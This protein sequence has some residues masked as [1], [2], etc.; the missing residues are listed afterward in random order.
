MIKQNENR[1]TVGSKTSTVRPPSTVQIMPESLAGIIWRSRLIVFVTTLAA[2]I[3]VLVY[4][5]KTAP[6]YM[7]TSRIYVEQSG[8]KIISETEEGI[9]TQSN[10]YLYTQAELLKSTPILATVVDTA[11][12]KQTQTFAKVD[13][14]VALLKSALNVR[15]GTK[16]DIISV[17][18]KSPYPAEAAQIVNAVVDSYKQYHTSRKRSNS[19][20]VLKILQNEK[21]KRDKELKEKLK[22]MMDF[23]RENDSLAFE[24]D[25]GNIVI[26]RLGKLSTFLTEAQFATIESKSAYESAKA[27]ISDPARFTQF[28]EAQ[29][30][31]GVYVSTVNEKGVLISKLDQLQ[32]RLEDRLRQVTPEHP[33]VTSLENEIAHIKSQINQMDAD[34]AEAQL[35]VLEQQYLAAKEKEAQIAE[36][37]EDQ[38]QLALNL[39]EQL[40]QFTILQS[41]WEQ[42]KKLCDILGDRIKEVN[43]TEDVGALNISILEV[44]RQ[45]N[46]PSEPQKG[47]YVGIALIIGLMLGCALALLRDWMDQT[48]RSTEEILSVLGVPV[49]GV[50]PSIQGDRS[51][52]ARGR[53]VHFEPNSPAAEAYRAIRTSVFFGMP[54][55]NAKTI[56]ITSAESLEGKTTLASNLAITMAQAGQKS[57]LLD[58]DFRNPMQYKIFETNGGNGLVSLLSGTT[59]LER[60]IHPTGIDGLEL[61]PCKTQLVNSAEI[62]N[63]KSFTKLI[64]DL[65]DRYDRII[66]DSPP[67]LP[68]TDAQILSAISDITLL[69]LRAD[70]S[71]RKSGRLA[72]DGLLSVGANLLGVVV[73]NA[74][75]KGHYGYHSDY[76]YYQG[77]YV[78]ESRKQEK[79]NH[80]KS[81]AVAE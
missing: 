22:T 79:T 38:R 27:M 43:V 29:R 70:K 46:K 19:A 16:D 30:A 7:S 80:D 76:G 75:K 67:V 62:I 14:P 39:N 26:E 41:D 51:I 53:R 1:N 12:I 9:M 68:V 55:N 49:L 47:R 58:A 34:F 23:K 33:A 2:L 36:Y 66:I 8:P 5:I 59:T 15:V 25:K 13:S 32:L 74:S 64:K 21:D 18:F 44:A 65:S 42:T 35:A 56:L 6:I 45:A 20:E 57:L 54:D 72:R 50:I 10:N 40:A 28:T 81:K 63:S 37:Y 52:L 73:N 77:K 24:S 31:K 17:S 60:A 4:L 11:D 61:L 71:T 78:L 69:V 3:A 48:L